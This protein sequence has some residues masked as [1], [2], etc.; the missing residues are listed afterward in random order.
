MIIS[1]S[2]LYKT[3]DMEGAKLSSMVLEFWEMLKNI[4][5]LLVRLET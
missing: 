5:L 3:I 4:S 1:Y 2:V